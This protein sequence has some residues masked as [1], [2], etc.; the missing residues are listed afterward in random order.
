MS[1]TMPIFT[2]PAP[3]LPIVRL[4]RGDGRQNFGKPEAAAVDPK[5][6]AKDLLPG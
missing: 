5:S 4:F 2:R 3:P 1:E 6:S